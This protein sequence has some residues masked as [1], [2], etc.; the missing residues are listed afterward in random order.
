MTILNRHIGRHVLSGAMMALVVLVGIDTAFALATEVS[1][2]GTGEYGLAESLLYTAL[3]VP[4][5]AYDF[6]PLAAVVGSMVVLGGLAAQSEF[7]AMRGAGVSA[8]Q[9]TAAIL[10]GG[11]LL[12]LLAIILGEAVVPYSEFYAQQLRAFARTQSSVIKSRHGVWA[13][14][15]GSF[16]NIAAVHPGGELRGVEIYEFDDAFALRVKTTARRAVFEQPGRDNVQGRAWMLH[17]ITRFHFTERGIAVT[18]LDTTRWDAQLRPELLE[19]LAV[20]PEQL[21]V[22]RL[23]GYLDYLR[24][25]GLD[26]QPYVFALWGKV[27][28]PFAILVMLYISAPFVFAPLRAGGAGQRIVI[29][30]MLGAGYYLLS[31]SMGKIGQVYDLNPI[32][33][34]ALPALLFALAGVP[35]LRAIDVSARR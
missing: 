26:T 15:R 8:A 4:R 10:R 7:V 1:G 5:R 35:A 18:T 19:V 13:R 33:S 34:N 16:V 29:G 9:I 2:I 3:T 30:I 14:D 6:L 24:E 12:V 17:D 27:M 23:V 25:N 31:H 22:W 32:F 20:K 11:A 21:P 28:A